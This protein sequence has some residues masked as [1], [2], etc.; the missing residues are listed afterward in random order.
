MDLFCWDFG[1]LPAGFPLTPIPRC[2]PRVVNNPRCV[3]PSA[4]FQG[5]R[6][7]AQCCSSNPVSGAA[8]SPGSSGIYTWKNSAWSEWNTSSWKRPL[9]RR[10]CPLRCSRLV[11]GALCSLWSGERD[12]L[13][14]I[15]SWQPQQFPPGI[16][17]LLLGASYMEQSDLYLISTKRA[18]TLRA[19]FITCHKDAA[20]VSPEQNFGEDMGN[21]D[22]PG[23]RSALPFPLPN[24]CPLFLA[25]GQCR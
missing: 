13:W 17:E 23:I 1:A 12:E 2:E 11:T 10:S 8:G 15:H 20:L 7:S 5:H 24:R 18:D 21:R 22:L 25:P 3:S 14:I 4:L 6:F 16:S 19:S 9:P